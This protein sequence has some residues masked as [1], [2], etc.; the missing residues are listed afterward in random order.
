LNSSLITV[1]LDYSGAVDDDPDYGF[2]LVGNPFSASL[3]FKKGGASLGNN[4]NQTIWIWDPDHNN[5]NGTYGRYSFFSWQGGGNYNGVVPVGQAFLVQATSS[6][7]SWIKMDPEYRVYGFDNWLKKSEGDWD[8][9][10]GLGTY[11]MLKVTNGT[12]KDA[13]FI[14]FGENGTDGYEN[15][16]D[17][18]KFIGNLSAPQLY[19][20]QEGENL[21]VD[22][23]ASLEDNSERIVSLSSMLPFLETIP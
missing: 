22:Y 3:N 5:G 16:Y 12:S 15:G 14:S 18:K 19:L 20:K 7:D 6:T 11:V 17:A 2:N 23:L 8:D 21:S 1:D 10:F 9:N 4:I 13:A